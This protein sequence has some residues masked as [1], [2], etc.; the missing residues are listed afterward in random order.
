MIEGIA[1]V[2]NEKHIPIKDKIPMASDRG[3]GARLYMNIRH[4]GNGSIH[5]DGKSPGPESIRGPGDELNVIEIVTPHDGKRY[6]TGVAYS[7]KDFEDDVGRTNERYP[8][9]EDGRSDPITKLHHDYHINSSLS[10]S[11]GTKMY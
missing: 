2:G 1:A 6:K 5:S 10:N 3:C 8:T 9:L 4:R 7:E 11:P